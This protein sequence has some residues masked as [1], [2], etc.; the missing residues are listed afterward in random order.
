MEKVNSSEI[1]SVFRRDPESR[2]GVKAGYGTSVNTLFAGVIAFVLTVLFFTVVFFLPD[3]GFKAAM[4]DRGPT[5]Y[6]CVFLG[7]WS[8]TILYLKRL[9][10]KIQRSALELSVIP[11]NSDFVL[12]S[13]SADDLISNIYRLSEDPERLIVFNRIL[14]AVSNLKNLGRVSDVDDILRSIGERDEAAH[15]TSFAITGGFLWAIPVLGFIGTVLGLAGAIGNF[16]EILTDDANINLVIGSL[17]EVTGGL[18]TAFET[19]LVALVIALVVQLWVTAQRKAE[20]NFLDDCSGYCLRYIV[21]R[22]KILP[23]EEVREI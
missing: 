21:N 6:A 11:P 1:I 7:I 5:Q 23:F 18:S 12:S 13:Q 3:S 2:L 15:E 16:S 14:I 19:T 10:L 4:L 20:E 17:K 8:G 9:K 22:I